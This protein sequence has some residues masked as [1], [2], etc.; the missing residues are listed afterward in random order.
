MLL[1]VLAACTVDY[2]EEPVTVYVRA[3]EPLDPY[4]SD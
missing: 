4:N 1:L 3:A 2:G